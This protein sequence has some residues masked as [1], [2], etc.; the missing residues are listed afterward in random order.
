MI[1]SNNKIHSNYLLNIDANPCLTEEINNNYILPI[2][3]RFFKAKAIKNYSLLENIDLFNDLDY[4][5]YPF[6]HFYEVVLGDICRLDN[7]LI[8]FS[9]KY[10]I[11]FDKFFC[12][13]KCDISHT[14]YNNLLLSN[15]PVLYFIYVDFEDLMTHI[16]SV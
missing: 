6:D 10:A 12:N 8:S 2:V 9:K 1:N 14:Y 3:S 5:S 7:G 16:R 4:N 13:K 11:S 15:E